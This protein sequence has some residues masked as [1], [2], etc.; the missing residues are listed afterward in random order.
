MKLEPQQV[1]V[2]KNLLTNHGNKFTADNLPKILAENPDSKFTAEFENIQKT[3]KVDYAVLA[4]FLN[5]IIGV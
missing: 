4:N 5:Q 1:V 3:T 2:L